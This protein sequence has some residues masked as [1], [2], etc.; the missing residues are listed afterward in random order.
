MRNEKGPLLLEA[1]GYGGLTIAPT[2]D[3]SRLSL[4]ERGF[5]YAIAQVR[6]GGGMGR[7]WHEDGAGLRK[8]NSFTD[9]IACAEY[10][11]AQRYTSAD[12]IAMM[13]TSAGGLLVGAVAN[14]RPDLF[15]AV[16]AKVPWVDLIVPASDLSRVQVAGE[17]G[18]PNERDTYQ[19]IKS[20]SPYDNVK[21]QRYPDMLITAGFNDATLEP[22][23][24]A[25]RLRA[26]NSGDSVLLLRMNM[27]AAHREASD[28][29]R[30]T[31][32]DRV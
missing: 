19:Y 8:M 10:L 7:R 23:K 21:R 15:K 28:R 18:D 22:A 31:E 25:A 13:G 2:F 12:R 5:I 27:E 16:I 4:L 26:A 6:G 32:G 9:F 3:S 14:M 1:Y 24:W 20:Y 17:L 29:Y 30:A 11:I